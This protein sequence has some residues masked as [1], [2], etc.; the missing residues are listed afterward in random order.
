MRTSSRA[1]ICATP[2]NHTPEGG[3]RPRWRYPTTE[4]TYRLRTSGGLTPRE[5][6][7][8]IDFE[9]ADGDVVAQIPAPFM[10]DESDKES[11]YSEAVDLDLGRDD[12]GYKLTLA[13]DADW[14]TS[15]RREGAV[16]IDPT[17]VFKPPSP[18]CAITNTL[19][20]TR[21]VR[22]RLEHGRHDTAQAPVAAALH[23]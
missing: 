2:C 22:R 14:V 19:P 23:D 17:V 6:D 21:R 10:H 11:G 12:S 1:P 5:S 16:T 3:A 20:N 4:F 8:G 7:G 18:D 13:A 15:P 9:D